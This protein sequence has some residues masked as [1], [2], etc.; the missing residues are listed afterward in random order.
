MITIWLC[1][2]FSIVCSRLDDEIDASQQGFAFLSPLVSLCVCVCV[3]C[4]LHPHR[5]C[6]KTQTHSRTESVSLL[7]I[8]F[9]ICS[10]FLFFL[11]TEHPKILHNHFWIMVLFSRHFH[12]SFQPLLLFKQFFPLSMLSQLHTALNWTTRLDNLFAEYHI[13]MPILMTQFRFSTTS[14]RFYEFLQIVDAAVWL[15][16]L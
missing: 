10:F 9:I 11:F 8:H 4:S 13:R 2:L 12:F 15:F 1:G 3:C 7:H 6:K 16:S 14:R 5:L